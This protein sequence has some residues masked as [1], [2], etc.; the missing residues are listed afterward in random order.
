MS[1]FLVAPYL[2]TYLVSDIRVTPAVAGSVI[3]LSYWFLRASGLSAA[4]FLRWLSVKQLML[5]GSTLRTIGYLP[6]L[7]SNF[8]LIIIGLAAVGVGAGLYF[9]LSKA[10]LNAIVPEDSQLKALSWR[11][12]YANIGVA[13]GPVLG[14][15]LLSLS[16]ATLIF[17]AAAIF[18][19]VSVLLLFLPHISLARE[20]EHRGL[21]LYSRVALTRRTSSVLAASFVLGGVFIQL[22][23]LLPL[24][25]K[26]N[27][28]EALIAI[29]FTAN[30]VLVV[31]GQGLGVLIV[32]RTTPRWSFLI[33]GSTAVIGLLLFG[34]TN[35]AWLFWIMGITVL[36]IG[37]VVLGLTNDNLIRGFKGDEQVAAYGIAGL[38]DATGGLAGAAL[39]AALFAGWQSGAGQVVPFIPIAAGAGVLV[40][41][42][43]VIA[44]H[45]TT[46]EEITAHD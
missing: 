9:P 46:T 8:T 28:V 35:P 31:A 10:Y 41:V 22:E 17:T 30:A 19:V 15:A 11:N 21:R 29:V 3:G 7:S 14:L 13:L 39:G 1:A 45:K 6:L 20:T 32:T 42:A 37:E 2:A 33:G 26:E 44:P 12:V 27:S 18:A 24:W 36:T 38:M 25:A 34:P 40:L 4:F 5:V 23:S 43:L 16:P